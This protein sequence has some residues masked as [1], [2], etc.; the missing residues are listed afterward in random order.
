[1]PPYAPWTPEQFDASVFQAVAGL[2]QTRLTV[3]SEI[4]EYVD[5]LFLK[6]P[7]ED[8]VSWIK[9][10]TPG[11]AGILASV[12]KDWANAEWTAEVLRS[13]LEEA[14]TEH[15]HEGNA[16]GLRLTPSACH[17]RMGLAGVSGRGGG[18]RRAARRGGYAA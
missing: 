11:A 7:P 6:Q 13:G 14:A 9:A 10:M 16:N 4:T 15:G 2:A 17:C 1:M 3:L 18:H 8:E 12:R 5:W